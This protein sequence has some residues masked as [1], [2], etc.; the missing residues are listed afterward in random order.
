MSYL[1]N[2]QNCDYYDICELGLLLPIFNVNLWTFQSSYENTTQ[3]F[4]WVALGVRNIKLW[5]VLYLFVV[6][7]VVG[8]AV[9]GKWLTGGVMWT[10]ASW[11]TQQPE[12]FIFESLT[13]LTKV[14]E[15]TISAPQC[16]EFLATDAFFPVSFRWKGLFFFFYWI[17]LSSHKQWLC[18]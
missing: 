14:D 6:V 2:E 11:K 3:L 15:S 12:W 10:N 7:V 16:T 18:I 4:L 9:I 8:S 1:N 17:S 13:L 5:G